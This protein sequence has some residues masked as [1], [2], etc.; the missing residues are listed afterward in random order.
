MVEAVI[1][2]VLLALRGPDAAVSWLDSRISNQWHRYVGPF[3]CTGL[4]VLA[5]EMPGAGLTAAL[6][7]LSDWWPF[8]TAIVGVSSTRTRTS[9]PS[10]KLHR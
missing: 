9:S 5:Y 4:D 1:L 2:L 10:T 6:W 3:V 7:W 8:R